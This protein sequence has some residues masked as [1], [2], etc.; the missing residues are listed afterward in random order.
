MSTQEMLSTE[1]I[2]KY[3]RVA[4][5]KAITVDNTSSQEVADEY[6]QF[7]MHGIEVLILNKKAFSGSYQLWQNLLSAATT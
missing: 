4:S 3:L 2:V 6:P 7:L 1:Q 5:G